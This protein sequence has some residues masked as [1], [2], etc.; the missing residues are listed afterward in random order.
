[1]CLWGARRLHLLKVRRKS[2]EPE[3]FQGS[4]TEEV[5]RCLVRA[6]IPT[7]P[8]KLDLCLYHSLM[9]VCVCYVGVY[10][11]YAV[12][13][14]IYAC[15]CVVGYVCTVCMHLYV[16]CAVCMYLCVCWVHRGHAKIV[17]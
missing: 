5:L 1:M 4:K 11:L 2:G 12:Y 13:V 14:C 15:L 17:Y 7:T 3:V 6:V 8:S 10:V 16:L 9:C